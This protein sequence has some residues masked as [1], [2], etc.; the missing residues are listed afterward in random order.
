MTGD[1]ITHYIQ[2]P[3]GPAIRFRIWNR[4]RPIVRIRGDFGYFTLTVSNPTSR[5]A[6]ENVVIEKFGGPEELRP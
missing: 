1:R 6:H 2:Q 5:S 3:R 4:C